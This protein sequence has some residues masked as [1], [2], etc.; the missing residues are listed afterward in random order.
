MLHFL[1]YCRPL[2]RISCLS[3]L[4]W[5]L[6]MSFA[7]G[8]PQ[9]RSADRTLLIQFDP[10]TRSLQGEL[11]QPLATER[12]FR[13]LEGLTVTSATRGDDEL[14]VVQEA[15]G[16]WHLPLDADAA[17]STTPIT[18]RWEGTLPQASN[19]SRHQV[20]AEGSLLPTRAGWYPHLSDSAAPLWLTVSVPDGQLAVATG[21][22]VDEQHADSAPY[23]A[24]FYH[25][26]TREVE[27]AT[28]PWRLRQ[29]EVEGV[30]LR[31]LFPEALDGA[32]GETYL[33][34]AAEQL[35]RFQA[36]LGPLPY[37]SFSIAASPAPV[38][39][40][41]PGFTLLGERVIPLPFIPHTSLPHELMHA[42]WGAGVRVDYPSGNWAEALTTY[43]ADYALAEQRGED[44]DMRRRWLA[45]LAALP[46][47]QETALMDFRGSPDPAGRLIGYQHGAMLFHMLRQRIGD[48]AFD[49]GLRHFAD[50]W[51]HRT[52]DWQALI[53]AFSM[54]SGEPQDAF[55]MP[56]ISQPGRPTLHVEPIKTQAYE[57]GYRISGM[58]IQRGQHAPWPMEVPLVVTTEEGPVNVRQPMHD[59]QQTFEL[60][61]ASRPLSLEVDPGADLLRHPG[62]T[63]AILR[64]LM[65]DPTTR[66]LALDDALFPLAR[67]VL[68]RDA[69]ALTT[70]VNLQDEAQPPLL[71]IG[72]TEAVSDWY[73]RIALPEPPQPI[74]SAEDARFW[75]APGTPIGLL[76]GNDAVAI[77]QL[78]ASLRHH[79][80]QS[81]VVQSQG[82]E[83]VQT[84]RWPTEDFPLSVT[85]TANDFQE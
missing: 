63:P 78:A 39:L 37:T 20:A 46:S 12:R 28:G 27:I 79:G 45:D 70:P 21:S 23:V 69:E 59:A 10:T 48:E 17:G 76:S 40:A 36:S 16:R 29:R 2:L 62:P 9:E 24:R 49:L 56:W 57:D 1:R 50:Q 13:L 42:W 80:Q 53:D 60:H 74:A 67:Q 44:D 43:L 47:R 7:W 8:T 38:G 41:F 55:I 72:T 22:L 83:T 64:Q 84:G 82:G 51:M 73:Q 71:V 30:Q 81:Y 6:A 19:G 32:F 68:G 65:L 15:D 52:A 5:L 34:H 85:F 77:T 4:L 11:H 66:V 3:T 14:T 31:T 26:N 25:P 54:A 58:L 75:M 33:Q 35:A 61:L 18:L